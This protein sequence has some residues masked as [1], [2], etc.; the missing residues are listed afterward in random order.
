MMDLKI[1]TLGNF[2]IKIKDESLVEE[3]GRSYKIFKLLH[4]F[5]TFRNKRL[6]PESIM[7]SLFED[8][9]S[10]DPKNMLRAQIYRLRQ[11]LKTI[12]PEGADEKDYISIG[13]YNGYYML[14]LGKHVKLDVDKFESLIKEG[15]HVREIDRKK[16]ID[17][18]KEAI[19]IYRGHFLEENS[20]E[21][22]LIPFRN[23]YKKIYIM[24]I[25]NL[26]DL[27]KEKNKHDEIIEICQDTQPYLKDE[28]GLHVYLME[29]MLSLGKVRNALNHYEF[30]TSS[31][32][33]NINSNSPLMKNIYKKIHNSIY[34]NEN[35]DITNM[36]IKLD[37]E[38]GS[39]PLQC[40][41]DYFKF[42]YSSHKRKRKEDGKK[43][44]LLIITLDENKHTRE[45]IDG[46]N[47]LIKDS[48][49]RLLRKSDIFTF[50]NDNQ[51]LVLLKDVHDGG[52]E[53]IEARIKQ[54]FKSQ[55][56]FDIGIRYKPINNK[57]TLEKLS[58]S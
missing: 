8:S 16:A 4:Y 22:W 58:N 35:L 39:G 19:D 53:I 10:F 31:S 54:N 44:F 23:Y 33:E 5:L 36:E 26:L 38:E 14:E 20:Q 27:L 15:D 12:L 29:A 32:N 55:D 40:S 6:L 56:A 57:E 52:I 2:N 17:I 50:W 42:L 13:F 24:A 18:Y 51:A 1:T 7:N 37:E 30:I 41:I 28:E 21:V 46:W 48:L 34:E 9:E 43:D 47:T 25:F 45:D 49:N 11:S 3:F